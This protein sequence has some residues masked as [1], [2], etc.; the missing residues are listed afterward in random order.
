MIDLL[1]STRH[2]GLLFSLLLV[3][4]L[5]LIF[6][7]LIRPDTGVR[8]GFEHLA[9]ILV[10]EMPPGAFTPPVCEDGTSTL[11]TQVYA[12][13][14]PTEDAWVTLLASSLE[15]EGI[16]PGL[17]RR[18]LRFDVADATAAQRVLAEELPAALTPAELAK[19]LRVVVGRHGPPGRDLFLTQAW[20]AHPSLRGVPRVEQPVRSFDLEPTLLD[21]MG[22]RVPLGRRGLSLIGTVR[23][24]DNSPRM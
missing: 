3:L 11:C 23:G 15:A 6:R 10:D 4:T 16:G 21:F 8:A 12:E 19:T 13:K 1:R 20:L 7:F 9:L 24:W 17:G 5:L 22:A 18:L 14:R 2:R